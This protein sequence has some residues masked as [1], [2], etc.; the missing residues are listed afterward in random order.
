MERGRRITL[1]MLNDSELMRGY[2]L[3]GTGIMFVVALASPSQ[4]NNARDE[5]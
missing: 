2:R 4:H 5:K 1:Q 3:D